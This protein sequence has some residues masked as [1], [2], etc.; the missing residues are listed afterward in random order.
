MSHELVKD[1]RK[2]NRADRS[3]GA[4]TIYYFIL[5]AHSYT[6]WRIRGNDAYEKKYFVL[7]FYVNNVFIVQGLVEKRS[8]STCSCSRV[9]KKTIHHNIIILFVNTEIKQLVSNRFYSFWN[10]S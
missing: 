3:A 7:F 9:E 4:G 6:P 5:V 10:L 2:H 1:S 8:N